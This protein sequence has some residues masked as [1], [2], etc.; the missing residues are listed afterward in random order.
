MVLKASKK[1]K[2]LRGQ[3][4]YIKPDKTKAEVAE[5]Q[6]LGKRKTELEGKY[7]TTDGEEKRVVLEKG[8][9]KVDGVQ[10]DEYKST[11]SLF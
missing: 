6:R 2:E 9:L 3:T 1:L 11:Q 4:I 5:Y 8:V 10:V 7:P